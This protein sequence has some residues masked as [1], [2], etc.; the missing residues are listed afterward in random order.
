MIKNIIKNKKVLVI[1]GTGF[2]GKKLVKRLLDYN[3]E[4]IRVL[5]R[6]DSK[7]FIMRHELNDDDRL[8]WLIGDVRDKN[9]LVSAMRD[10]D[11]VFNAA[12]IKHVPASEYN[13]FE[14]VKT[15]VMGIQNIVESAIEN[16]VKKVINM[17]TD[18]ATSPSNVMG[19]T[20]L[21]GEKLLAASSGLGGTKTK[22]ASVRFGNV[23]GSRGSV[24]PLFM[25]Q[26]ENGG[27]VT[28]THKEMQRFV[29]TVDQAIDLLLVSADIMQGGEVFLF[30][31]PVIK[32]DELA[33][34][35]TEMMTGTDI[36]KKYV[37]LRQGETLDED[38][39]T[40]EECMRTLETDKM[41]IILPTTEKAED[42]SHNSKKVDNNFKYSSETQEPVSKEELKSI[43]E[44][45]LS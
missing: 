15:N 28:V 21:L 41:F 1:G 37:G 30:K 4:V 44:E 10:I 34:L 40:Q 25:H 7:Q 39:L 5:S 18:K 2:V 11:V 35:M 16:N 31:M 43:L 32:V 38:L 3:P 27:P 20:K 42:Y 33:D 24:V 9:R 17:S 13:P 36:E 22:F 26:I 19:A 23:L 45:V 6:D 29:I 14:A 8:R 12:A